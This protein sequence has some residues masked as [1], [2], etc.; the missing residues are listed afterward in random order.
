MLSCKALAQLHASDYLDHTL[1]TRERLG[2][3][4]HL[5]LCKNCRRFIGQL[6]VV[7]D[8][9]RRSPPPL[10]ETRVQ[11]IAAQMHKAYHEQKKS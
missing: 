1:T 2:V 8:V 3:R 4:L 7:R 10:E 9:L 11:A 6:Q 5:I